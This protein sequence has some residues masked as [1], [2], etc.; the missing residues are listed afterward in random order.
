MKDLIRFC[1]DKMPKSVYFIKLEL[2]AKWRQQL[3]TLKYKSCS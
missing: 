3:E 2:Y 1:L